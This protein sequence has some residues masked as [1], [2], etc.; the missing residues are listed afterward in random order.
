MRIGICKNEDAERWDCFVASTAQ[1]NC[2]HQIKWKRLI[3]E[4]FGLRTI[5]LLTEDNEHRITGILPLVHLRSVVFGNFMVSMPYFNYGGVC[6]TDEASRSLLLEE[7]TRIAKRESVDHI[8]FRDTRLLE[9]GLQRKESKVSM[10]LPLHGSSDELWKSIGSKLRSQVNRPIK[11]G[12]YSKIGK[13]DE[14]DNF[15]EVF[16][17]NMR[18]L[19]TPV[20]SKNFFRNILRTF[21]ESSWICTVFTKEKKAV[22]SGFLIGFKGTLEIPWASSLRSQNKYSPNMLLY[23]NAIKFGCDTGYKEF[24]FGRSTPDEG[25]YRFKEQWGARPHPLY[26]YYWTKNGGPIPELNPKNPKYRAAINVWKRLPVG[27]TR[28]IGPS[29]VKNLP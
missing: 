10:R 9:N 21:S 22:A 29:I 16:S 28:M 23:W 17:R 6:A 1:A 18:D 27:I 25:T 14:L 15:Y 2:Y 12:M 24:D 4:S 13:E 11:E 19:G 20:Y 7:A 26:W 5:Y 3:E 8:E